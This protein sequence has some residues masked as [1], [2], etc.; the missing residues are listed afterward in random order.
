MN[1][2]DIRQR[3]EEE[4]TKLESEMSSI[5]HRNPHFAGDWEPL[6]P[7]VGTEADLVDQADNFVNRDNE[8]AIFSDLEV[9]YEA[10]LAALQ[11]GTYGV[12]KVCGMPIE[13]A[14]LAVDPAATTC[15]AH[16]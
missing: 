14:R 11:K 16:R 9:R 2:E 13:E 10:V 7:E 3:L 1:K 8:E 6:P 4:K 15:I 12:C 5:G